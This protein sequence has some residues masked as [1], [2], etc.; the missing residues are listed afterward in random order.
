LTLNVCDVDVLNSVVLK[1]F[2]IN[3]VVVPVAIRLTYSVVLFFTS[4]EL[5][6][7]TVLP[8][9]INPFVLLTLIA[10]CVV[11]FTFCMVNTLD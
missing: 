4:S 5:V 7:N 10:T 9:T 3:R 6:L 11:L 8:L 1:L 2:T